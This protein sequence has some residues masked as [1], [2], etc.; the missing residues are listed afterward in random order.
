MSSRDRSTVQRVRAVVVDYGGG[1]LTLRCLHALAA[2]EWP[3]E[4]EIV[5]VD[6]ASPVKVVDAVQAG[7][8]QVKIV[9]SGVNRGFA[10]GANLGIGDP[11]EVDAVALVNNDAVVD[12]RWLGPLVSALDGDDRLGAASPKMVLPDRW[13]PLDLDAPVHAVG[14]LDRRTVGVQLR[15]ARGPGKVLAV[16]GF[17]GP[18]RDGQGTFQW[19]G[20]AARLLVAV[21]GAEA[22]GGA[23]VTVELDL[24]APQPTPVTIEAG[25]PPEVVTVGRTPVTVPVA[26]TGVPG[27]RLNNAGTDLRPDWY[28]VDR[29]LYA[30]DDGSWDE[31]GPLTA[32]CGGAVL[33]RAGYLLDAGL[34]DERLFLYY[35]DLELSLRGAARGWRYRYE[36]ASVV[37]HEHGATAEAGS[38]L[39]EFYKE[40]N[41]LLVATRYAP[42]MV[43]A[44]LTARFVAST[45][46][47]AKRDVLSPVLRGGLP[48]AGILRVRARSLAGAAR[49]AP[50][51][52]RSQASE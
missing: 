9:A 24:S 32:W 47:Y 46:S 1:P 29:G 11:A 50:A 44:R 30:L 36:P 40:R 4:M 26:A 27:R 16:E 31:P 17:W 7:L 37:V 8:P 10:G 52:C 2:T 43:A 5:L 41:R 15:G 35:E 42:P 13:L 6:N 3:G 48:H 18:E 34:F 38:P 51:F 19:T 23:A 25:G 28:G 22:G 45:L 39:I 14:G 21:A 20:S 12:P 33:L 49:L